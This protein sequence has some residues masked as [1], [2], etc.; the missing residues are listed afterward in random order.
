MKQAKLIAI[1]DPS[2]SVRCEEVSAP[3]EPGDG[4]VLVDVAAGPI[5]PAE[6]LIMKGEYAATPDLP[7]PLGIEG[8]GTVS[9]VGPGVSGLS[10]GDKVMLMP[11]ANWVQQALVS[12][13]EVIKLPAGIDLRQAAMLKVNPATAFLMLTTYVD[14]APGDWVAQNSANSAVGTSL[15]KIAKQRGLKTVNIVRREEAAAY[16][17]DIGGDVVVVDG[18]DVAARV[19]EATG[20]API[21]LGIDAV[22]GESVIRLAACLADGGTVVNYGM[23]SGKPCMLTTDQTVFQSKS[24]TGFW[25]AKVLGGMD[26]AGKDALY[27]EL[28][29]LVVDGTITVP[30]EA[31]YPID[32]IRDAVAH[33]CREGRSGKVL[34]LPNG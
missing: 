5:N 11:R 6:V 34:V 18:E 14:L 4:Q 25:L 17:R 8:A 23:L 30:I 24:L 21:K 32:R 2:T 31:A 12:A 13:E 26:K 29:P 27:A 28:A 33:A 22:A 20:G 16:C 19:A 9:A 15:I 1:G 3:G 7:A 10:V